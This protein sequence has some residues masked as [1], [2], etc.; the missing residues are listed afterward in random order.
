LHA[1]PRAELL[2]NKELLATGDIIGFLSQ[3]PGLDYFHT[4]FVIVGDS[5]ELTLRHAAKSRGRVLDEP[6]ARFL[7]A[8]RVKAVTVL[9]P[10]EPE[11]AP[12]LI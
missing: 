4:G 2:A 8:N 11:G 7:A 12:A 3:Q 1:V 10:R 9:R 5:G 6:L